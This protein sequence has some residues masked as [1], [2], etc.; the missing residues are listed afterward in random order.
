MLTV[1]LDTAKLS[2]EELANV[3][4]VLRCRCADCIAEGVAPNRRHAP[5]VLRFLDELATAID[6]ERHL[7]AGR[8][9]RASHE[10]DATGVP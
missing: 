8:E 5:E 2:D 10:A 9:P 4:H 6:R 1:H 3:L 7:R